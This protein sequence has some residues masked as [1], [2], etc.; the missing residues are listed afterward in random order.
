MSELPRA[1]ILEVTPAEYYADPCAVPSLTQSIAHVLLEQSPAHA[2]AA[3]PRLGN[4]SRDS[5]RAQDEG[6]LIHALLLGR[7]AE[8]E[9]IDAPDFRTNRARELRD[10]AQAE[11]RL[12]VLRDKHDQAVEIADELRARIQAFG[13]DPAAGEHE[14]AIEWIEDGDA[15][16]VV[17]R[18]LI[19]IVDLD[20]GRIL[21]V[22][23]IRS[24]DPRTCSRHAIEYGY[25]TQHAAYTSAVE[26]LRPDLVGRV[27]FLF[28]FVELE[29]PYAVVPCRPDGALREIGHRR[30]S[31]AIRT[32][33]RCLRANDWPAFT[34]EITTLEAPPWAI[35]EEERHGS[36]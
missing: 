12:P 31:R 2:W 34:R 16:D 22:K 6:T 1:R 36:L 26:K 18:G 21:D 25:A 5:S 19:D 29:P 15:D 13:L 33:E 3:H 28:V 30:W 32:W 9:I 27:D 14:L 4:A 10:N 24:A 11:G 8:I 20:L 7:G 17:C 23:K 35:A